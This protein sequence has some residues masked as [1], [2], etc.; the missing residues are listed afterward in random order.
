MNVVGNPLILSLISTAVAFVAQG[1]MFHISKSK[2]IIWGEWDMF[3]LSFSTFDGNC[4]T[5][6]DFSITTPAAAP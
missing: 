6:P 5:V 1:K 3:F 4:L 2:T